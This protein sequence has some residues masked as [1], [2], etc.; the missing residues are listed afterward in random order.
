[1]SE[2]M[3]P[4]AAPALGRPWAERF[5][6]PAPQ[7]ALVGGRLDLREGIRVL[8]FLPTERHH[9]LWHRWIG[10]E[11]EAALFL[12]PLDPAVR[13]LRLTVLAPQDPAPLGGIHLFYDGMALEVLP[14]AAPPAVTALV[15]GAWALEALLPPA[16]TL[17]RQTWSR[18]DIRLGRTLP[19]AGAGHHQWR[20]L[21]LHSVEF[22]G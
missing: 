18:L 2:T 5:P 20:G 12:G 19:E 3:S 11:P 15:P 10:P 16:D 4:P 17:P 21:A 22:L 9:G 1:M 8:G 14:A 13:A 7:P 6:G